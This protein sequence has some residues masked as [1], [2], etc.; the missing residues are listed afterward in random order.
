MRYVVYGA[1]AI[2]G[3]VGGLLHRAGIDTTLVARGNHLAAL[4]D[5]GL[6]LT[7]GHDGEVAL[8]V[9]TA[10]SAAEVVW[11][12]DTVV[13]LAVKSQQTAAALA[14]LT[15]HLPPA[16]PVVSLQNGVSNERTLLRH[17]EHVQ[18]IVVMMPASHLSPGRVTIH[19]AGKPGLLDV[20]RF[21]SGVDDTSRAVAADLERAGFASVPRDDVMAWKHRKLLMNLGNAV[22]ASCPPG[23]EATELVR[24][25]RD[26]GERVLAAAGIPVTGEADDR[27]RRGELLRPL[28]DRDGVGSS[29]WQ[30]V[31]R[32]TGDVEADHL[33]GEIVLLG[34]L[35]GLL[36]PA[37]ELARRTVN[38][39]V[40]RA[41]PPQTVSAAGLL[42]ELGVSRP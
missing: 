14:D 22:N 9:P 40:R 16:T 11:H 8:T 10:A 39:L 21:P 30:S 26:E 23:D 17:V 20:G 41:A 15:P 32:G 35:H 42:A 37:N 19:S 29:S 27:E 2:G 13:L 4:R 28:V 18:G 7:V 36:T 1:G 33:N 5:D 31:Q 6:R 24:L 34:R 3:G 12:D 25:V 38:D